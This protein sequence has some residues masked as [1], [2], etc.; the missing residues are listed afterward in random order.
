L[1]RTG[2]VSERRGRRHDQGER[3][4]L[5]AFLFERSHERGDGAIAMT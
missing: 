2:Q 5:D 1:I 4:R 3:Q